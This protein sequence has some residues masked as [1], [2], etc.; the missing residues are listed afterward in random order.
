MSEKKYRVGIIGS[1]PI[2][3]FYAQGYQSVDEVEM[4]AVANPV[5]SVPDNFGQQFGIEN[6]NL[7]AR[8]MLDQEDLDIVSVATWH[9][10]HAPMTIAAFSVTLLV[11]LP[12]TLRF[13]PLA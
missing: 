2:A 5:Q 6:R 11:G 3:K 10:L 13:V 7:D 4:V 9:K 12:L 1:G 8:E